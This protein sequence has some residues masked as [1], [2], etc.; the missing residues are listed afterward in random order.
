MASPWTSSAA[1]LLYPGR[2]RGGGEC[3]RA[4]AATHPGQGHALRYR[5]KIMK[6]ILC[7]VTL[8]AAAGAAGATDE[9]Y[10][11]PFQ[12]P[13][14][15]TVVGT[16]QRFKAALPDKIP[17]KR[18]RLTVFKGRKIPEA[19]WYEEGLRYSYALQQ[20][21]AP[22]VF[23]IAGTGG[24]HD[25]GRNQI[26]AK[27]LYQAGFHVVG[28]P[29]P[30]F[31]NFIVSASE[32]GVPGHAYHDAADLYRV[33]TLVRDELQP[34]A[35][36]TGYSVAGYSLG[37]FNAAFVARLD[38]H[39]KAFSFDKVLMINPP[40]RLYSS[41]SLLDRM[42]ENIPGGEDNFNQYYKSLV[43]RLTQ[44]Y[45]REDR[46][47]LSEDGLYKAY[48]E[49]DFKNEELAALI[50]VSFRLTSAN[51]ALT[52]DI[53][54][55]AGYIK[56]K[57]LRLT[58]YSSIHPYDKVAMRLGF[59]DYVHAFF[60]PHYKARD[61]SLTREGLIE[62]M[63]LADIEEY[64]RGTTKIEVMHNQDDLILEPG[65]IEFFRRVF[66][67]RA[68]IYPYGGHCGNMDYRDNVMHMLSVLGQ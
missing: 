23:L 37:G 5:A 32:T 64:L 14:V 57:N 29:S 58:K 41:V 36:I 28:L 13:Y 66:G 38:E 2:I 20:G 53:M 11:Y 56:P 9:P 6:K 12:D 17:L 49:L 35:R 34:R 27:A 65:E 59:T 44:A 8:L 51:L 42:L 7:V 26:M 67:E 68:K 3:F 62:Q 31:A 1:T 40:V 46:L 39:E 30:T 21:A 52:S 19:L 63:N 18:A 43:E 55:N 60:Y 54:N 25:S 48:R 47:D 33:M 10:A 16:P 15:A 45:K 61:P 24:S 22:L 4:D 50:G